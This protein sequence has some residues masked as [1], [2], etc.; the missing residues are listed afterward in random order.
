MAFSRLIPRLGNLRCPNGIKIK[1][2][3]FAT[4]DMGYAP[5]V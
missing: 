3:F 4:D 5:R 1:E 2:I